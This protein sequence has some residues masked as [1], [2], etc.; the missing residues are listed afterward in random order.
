M[1]PYWAKGYIFSIKVVSFN[2]I[3]NGYNI[4]YFLTYAFQ[5]LIVLVITQLVCQS[6]S[7]DLR[8][9]DYI[10]DF[11]GKKLVLWAY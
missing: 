9:S 6:A 7:S 8:V 1:I 2:A 11:S 5:F 4:A 3:V 10:N